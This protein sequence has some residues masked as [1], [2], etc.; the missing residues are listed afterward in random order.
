MK[1]NN[2]NLIR[3]DWDISTIKD[4]V[5][6]DGVFCD[7]DWIESKDQ[8]PDGDVR[9]IQLADIGDGVFLNKS[10]RFFLFQFSYTCAISILTSSPSPTRFSFRMEVLLAR[11]MAT[12]PSQTAPSSGMEVL[13]ALLLERAL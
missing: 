1:T 11:F 12:A 10:C 2:H 9:L 3:L 7:G 4:L 13:G 8:N 5:S 6:K